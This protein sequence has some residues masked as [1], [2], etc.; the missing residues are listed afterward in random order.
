MI[1]P[2]TVQR[3]TPRATPDGFHALHLDCGS[4]LLARTV[5]VAAGVRWRSWTPRRRAI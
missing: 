5:L 4:E 3:I 2:V 1:A